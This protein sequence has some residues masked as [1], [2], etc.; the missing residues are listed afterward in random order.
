MMMGQHQRRHTADINCQYCWIGAYLHKQTGTESIYNG[1]DVV[2]N[3]Y[4]DR[5]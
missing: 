2:Q 1:Q 5:F 3:Q 4:Q